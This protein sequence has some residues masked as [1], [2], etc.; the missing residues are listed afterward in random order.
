MFLKQLPEKADIIIVGGGVT[1]AAIARELSKY[2]LDIV[3]IEK[4]SDVAFGVSKKNMGIIHPFIPQMGTL[5]AHLCLEGNKM[6]DELSKEL[7]FAFK[8]VGLLI[9]AL[10]LLESLFLRIVYLWLKRK[11]IQVRK[12]SRDEL[13][14]ME[15]NLNK[16]ARFALF[17]PTAGI[18]IPEEFVIALME[19]A[20]KNG[21]KV[22]I[23]TNVEKI[24]VENNAVVGVKTDKGII[25]TRCVINAAGMESDTVMSLAGLK[26][27]EM[28]PGIGVMVILNN[29]LKGFTNH[30]VAEVPFRVDPRT[31]GGGAGIDYFGRL[32]WGPNLRL[33]SNKYDEEIVEEDIKSL[34]KKF[35]R[36]FP[37]VEEDDIIY[38]FSGIRPASKEGDFIIG[39]TNIDGFINVAGIQ[40]PGLTAAPAVAKMVEEIIVKK[41][42]PKLKSNY[43]PKRERIKRVIEQPM[44]K[45]DKMIIDNPS[46]GNVLCKCAMITEGEVVEA[47]KRGARTIESVFVRLRVPI[48]KCRQDECIIKIA[49]ILSRELGIELEKVTFMGEGTSLGVEDA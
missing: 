38:F 8:R 43:D 27:F 12:I 29:K 47:I 19:N 33:V 35:R 49:E 10:N 21:V 30:I 48:D 25:K 20:V 31:K 28:E 17:V 13:F 14:E 34:L 36:L 39:E 15:P 2:E 4:E 44:D 41:F 46:Y 23:E 37:Q 40:S 1:G 45:V 5:K 22:V 24:L 6:F 3:L 18:T 11:G 7:D 42:S 16:K 26:P 32:I 9:V